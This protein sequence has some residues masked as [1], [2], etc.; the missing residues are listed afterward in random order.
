[1][2]EKQDYRDTVFLPKTDFPMKAGLAQKEPAILAHWAETKLYEQLRKVRAG[3][4]RFILHDGPP[5]ANGDIHMGHAMNKILKDIVVRSQ[6]LLGKDAPYVPGWDCHGLPIEWKVEEEYRKKKLDKDD[7]PR[8]QFRAECRA[9]A[10]KWVAVQSEQFQR[11]GV[12]GEWDDPY[13]TM[14]HEA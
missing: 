8:A 4:T 6:S 5:Y 14:K 3:R 11:L 13:L 1:M 9:Y 10:E 7:V 12:Q 2:S